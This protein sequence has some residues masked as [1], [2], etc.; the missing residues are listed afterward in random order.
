MRHTNARYQLSRFSSWRK[1]TVLSLAKSLLKY[2]QISTTLIRAKAARPVVERL[3]TDAKKNTLAGKRKAFSLLGEHKLVT[4]L[5]S[6]IAPRFKDING[7]YTRIL[8][9]GKRRGDNAEIA[10]FELTHKKEKKIKAKAA[11]AQAEPLGTEGEQVVDAEVT[12]HEKPSVSQKPKKFLGGIRKIFKKERD[13][14]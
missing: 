11:K 1:A 6:D 14:L 3:I 12:G 5:Y 2:E 8:K 9:M 10:L 4:A 13:S 7:G